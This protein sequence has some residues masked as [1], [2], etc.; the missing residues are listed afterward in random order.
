MSAV[1]QICFMLA[2]RNYQKS[3]IITN[4]NL[5]ELGFVK[6]KKTTTAEPSFPLIKIFR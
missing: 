4:K 6:L 1:K 3:I 2:K 5:I